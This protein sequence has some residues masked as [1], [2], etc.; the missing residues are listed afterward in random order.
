M[1]ILLCSYEDFR[2]LPPWPTG[3][4]NVFSYH[5]FFSQ[6]TIDSPTNTP[7]NATEHK[8]T[9]HLRALKS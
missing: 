4:S 2:Q 1:I 5:E 8:Q 7:T 9:C 3:A 6:P